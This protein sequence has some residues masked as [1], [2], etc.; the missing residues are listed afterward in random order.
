MELTQKKQV[1]ILG[2]IYKSWVDTIRFVDSIKAAS[3]MMSRSF[4]W[5]IVK[6]LPDLLLWKRSGVL[7]L[8]LILNQ[9]RI[10]GTFKV[11]DQD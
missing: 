6:L 7:I 1:L 4:L 3:E 2:V 8:L 11:Q 9:R 5:I 10:W